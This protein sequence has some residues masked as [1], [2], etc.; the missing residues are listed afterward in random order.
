MR[1]IT[2]TLLLLFG[3]DEAEFSSGKCPSSDA[4]LQELNLRF[5]G[6][7]ASDTTYIIYI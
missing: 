3:D 7:L 2:V 4:F 6:F 1:I 5:F